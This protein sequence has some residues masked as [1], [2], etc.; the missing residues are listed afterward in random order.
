MHYE[1]HQVVLYHDH[2]FR[3]S[4]KVST[5]A[6]RLFMGR[7]GSLTS[8]SFSDRSSSEYLNYILAFTNPFSFAYFIISFK[9]SPTLDFVTRKVNTNDGENKL[10]CSTAT[11]VFSGSTRYQIRIVFIHQPER[12]SIT[13][14][15]F[16]CA[17]GELLNRSKWILN[18][19]FL[20]SMFLKSWEGWGRSPS[21]Q[22]GSRARC[23]RHEP[24]A[25]AFRRCIVSL[26]LE[27]HLTL[28]HQIRWGI[29]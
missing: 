16:Y 10:F 25:F 14:R 26:I 19:F 1:Y 2:R 7:S 15:Y 12:K 28:F 17:E 9:V 3:C 5:L 6:V 21:P 11:F 18:T 24:V 27:I 13:Y 4:K 20:E 22:S 23:K 8:G 29:K